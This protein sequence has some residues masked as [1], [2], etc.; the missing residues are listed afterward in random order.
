MSPTGLDSAAAVAI[1]S[2]LEYGP[3]LC[4]DERRRVSGTC[5]SAA[6]KIELEKLGMDVSVFDA[7]RS[8]YG[9]F[10]DGLSLFLSSIVVFSAAAE[11]LIDGPFGKN[12]DESRYKIGRAHV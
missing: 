5:T 2:S 3:N 11:H 12:V 7:T 4:L 6:K 8:K 10:P 1:L 9:F